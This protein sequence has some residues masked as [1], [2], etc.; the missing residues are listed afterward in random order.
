MPSGAIMHQD[1][2]PKTIVD[3]ISD[4]DLV[5]LANRFAVSKHA[6]LIRLVSLGKVH[7]SFYWRVK[8]PQFLKEEEEYQGGGRSLYY[9][10]RYRNT[11]GDTYTGLVIEALETG[12]IG[13]LTAAEFMGIKN[14]QHLIDIKNN[15]LR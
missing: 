10:S 1:A 4:G 3:A 7:S 14:V 11:L 8:R 9:G 2:T 15:F 6:M 5:R 12:R 13:A